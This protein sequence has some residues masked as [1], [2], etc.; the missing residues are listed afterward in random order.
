MFCIYRNTSEVPGGHRGVGEIIEDIAR[1]KL[2]EDT[3][4]D[5]NSHVWPGTNKEDTDF[6]VCKDDCVCKKWD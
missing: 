4:I 5:W 1:R 2:K 6:K 3:L